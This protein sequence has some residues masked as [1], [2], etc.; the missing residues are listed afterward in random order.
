VTL[1]GVFV[2][3]Q[4]GDR[5]LKY[6]ANRPIPGLL[7]NQPGRQKK[8]HAGVFGGGPFECAHLTTRL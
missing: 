2:I 6:Y 3:I 4:V 7:S 1:S 5:S 8:G